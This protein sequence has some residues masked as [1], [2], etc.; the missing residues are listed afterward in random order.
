[1]SESE[2]SAQEVNTAL[3]NRCNTAIE[4]VKRMQI[5]IQEPFD[6]WVTS[7]MMGKELAKD[8]PSYASPDPIPD[9]CLEHIAST[10]ESIHARMQELMDYMKERGE[11]E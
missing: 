7:F 9:D 4:E 11:S 1:M 8:V 5:L 6:E 2:Q 10:L 3:L